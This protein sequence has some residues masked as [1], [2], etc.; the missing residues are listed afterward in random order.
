MTGLI[1]SLRQSFPGK[2]TFTGDNVA[3]LTGK[4]I[5]VTGAN[6]GVGKELAQILYSKNAKVYMLA[7][8]E[9]KTL[10]AMSEIRAAV[11]A[12]AGAL[13]YL[14]LDL[15][16]MPSVKATAAEFLRR[17]SRLDI[18]FNNAGVGYPPAGSTTAQGYELQV[19]VNCLGAF[20]LTHHLTPVLTATAAAAPLLPGAVRVVWASS[21]AAEAIAPKA[22]AAVYPN[23]VPEEETPET[24]TTTATAA[25]A[26]APK[27][28]RNPTYEL[29]FASKLGNYYLATEFA[30]RHRAA[31]IASV[32][33]NPGNL[34]SDLWRTLPAFMRWLLRK[35][36]LHP[37]VFGAYT[38]LFA[39]LSPDV[40]M[41]KSGVYVAPWGKFWNVARD[42]VDGTKTEAEGGTGIAR[43]FWEWTEEQ[44]APYL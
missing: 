33:L 26:A 31:G 10:G 20:A 1:S 40:T 44:V 36:V 4:V 34:D 3:D 29:Y 23:T 8:S 35:T 16:D 28:K 6:T 32:P 30:A 27:S 17:E 42:M 24:T 22:F 38:N 12:S 18:L 14:H 13:V 15:A 19:G 43:R 9:A 21:S 2:A 11:P 37:P 7:R 25:A 39:G 41:E 5:I